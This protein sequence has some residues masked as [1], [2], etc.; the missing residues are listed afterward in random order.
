[1]ACAFAAI[2]TGARLSSTSVSC[3]RQVHQQGSHAVLPALSTTRRTFAQTSVAAHEQRLPVSTFTEE[4]EMIR[5]MVKSFSNDV[6]LPRVRE[7]DRTGILDQVVIDGLFENGLMGIEVGEQYGGVGANFVS[8]CIAIEE[9]AKI[10]PAV[11]AGVDVHNTVVNN[12]VSMYGSEEIK[13]RFLPGLA[14]EHYGSFCL[15]ESGAGSDAFALK[16]KAEISA[17]GNS[18][19]INGQKLW[20]SNAE[21]AGILLVFANADFSKG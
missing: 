12:T 3:L 16:T 9:L 2:K 14:T 17:D 13:Q 11:S 15:S 20:I 5:D 21:N 1:M 6:I 8:S 10:D 18:Y 7:M 4:E 19:K